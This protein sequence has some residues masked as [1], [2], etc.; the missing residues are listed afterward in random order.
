MVWH[1]ES[2]W[3]T[4]S[5]LVIFHWK[6]PELIPFCLVL[7]VLKTKIYEFVEKIILILTKF[8]KNPKKNSQCGCSQT[9]ISWRQPQ[10]SSSVSLDRDS[11]PYCVPPVCVWPL[12]YC[13][14]L[15][16]RK[17][18]ELENKMKMEGRGEEA[19]IIL[20]RGARPFRKKIIIGCLRKSYFLTKVWRLEE[21]FKYLI[22]H[23]SNPCVACRVAA[24]TVTFL[25]G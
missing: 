19:V 6:Q 8:F 18:F 25:H 16:I 12:S 10:H 9:T 11:H 7:Y 20:K 17:T 2:L 1:S 23:E 22:L 5:K 3:H 14:V 13:R 15:E 21:F 4:L 24:S